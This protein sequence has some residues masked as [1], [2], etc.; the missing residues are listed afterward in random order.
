[1]SGALCDKQQVT[2]TTVS[3]LE[4]LKCFKTKVEFFS[5]GSELILVWDVDVVLS[6]P[7]S[8]KRKVRAYL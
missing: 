3:N 8:A 5:S 4:T 2:R 6:Q 1:M 7:A